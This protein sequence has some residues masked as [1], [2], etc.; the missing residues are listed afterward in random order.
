VSSHDNLRRQK[1]ILPRNGPPPNLSR[2]P[3]KP[4]FR[5]FRLDASLIGTKTHV[6]DMSRR[7]VVPDRKAEKHD[8]QKA[9]PR[10]QPSPVPAKPAPEDSD[11][12]YNPIGDL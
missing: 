7:M 4:S 2:N 9:D 1:P 6:V 5:T 12:P 11:W 8:K 3:P 10:E